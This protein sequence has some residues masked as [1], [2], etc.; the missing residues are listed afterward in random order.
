MTTYSSDKCV[1]SAQAF[2]GSFEPRD[3]TLLS[4][5]RGG[6]AGAGRILPLSS[7]A[8]GGDALIYNFI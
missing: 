3:V 1:F 2:L 6:R 7:N 8:G 4:Y 5:G